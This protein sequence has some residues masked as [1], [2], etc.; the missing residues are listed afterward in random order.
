MLLSSKLINKGMGSFFS[1]FHYRIQYTVKMH[2][3]TLKIRQFEH[4]YSR[5]YSCMFVFEVSNFGLIQLRGGTSSNHDKKMLLRSFNQETVKW[6]TCTKAE[7][8]LKLSLGS[9]WWIENTTAW[10]LWEQV[11]IVCVVHTRTAQTDAVQLPTYLRCS[12]DQWE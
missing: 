9:F 4:T 3:L 2:L 8:P 1:F 5:T 10:C 6:A 12:A 7:K 11:C